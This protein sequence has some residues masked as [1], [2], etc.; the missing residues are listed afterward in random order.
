VSKNFPNALVGVVIGKSQAGRLRY[1]NFFTSTFEFR[2]L[3]SYFSRRPGG[4]S[5]GV[6]SAKPPLD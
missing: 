2:P 3:C 1:F 5:S 4:K 6:P